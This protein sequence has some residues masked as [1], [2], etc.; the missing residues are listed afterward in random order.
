MTYTIQKKVRFADCDMAGI[1]F[2]PRYFEMLNAV[3]EDWF[4]NA[5]GCDFATL[6]QERGLGSPTVKLDS[7]F[8]APATLGEQM[9]VSINVEK[10]GNSSCSILYTISGEDRLRMRAKATLVCMDLAEQKSVPWPSDL[11]HAMEASLKVAA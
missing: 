11:R 1:V 8:V 10:L 5:L 4:E 6:H 3:L 9:L 7:E 2:Y